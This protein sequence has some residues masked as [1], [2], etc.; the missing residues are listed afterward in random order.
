MTILP[1]YPTTTQRRYWYKLLSVCIV[2]SRIVSMQNDDGNGTTSLM[3]ACSPAAAP[4]SWPDLSCWHHT[5]HECEHRSI[6]RLIDWSIC[7]RIVLVRM[8]PTTELVCISRW[9]SCSLRREHIS[10]CSTRWRMMNKSAAYRVYWKNY[11][12]SLHYPSINRWY[13]CVRIPRLHSTMR[14]SLDWRQ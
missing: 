5:S 14:S 9:S 8:I 3:W 1:H 6:D 7:C 13:Y 12:P 2:S 4:V 11:H 10:T